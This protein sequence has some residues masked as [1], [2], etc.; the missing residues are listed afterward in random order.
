MAV[1]WCLCQIHLTADNVGGFLELADRLQIEPVV[2][3]CLHYFKGLISKDIGLAL[4]R[5]AVTAPMQFNQ[6]SCSI[7][8]A[9]ND[10]NPRACALST[11]S[12]V[13][14]SERPSP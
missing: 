5:C 13:Q 7:V 12:F 8:T 3:A 10:L 2:T 4:Q 11:A 14:G 6:H 1:M 9:N